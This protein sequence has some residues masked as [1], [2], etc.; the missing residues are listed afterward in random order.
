MTFN[1]IFSHEHTEYVCLQK[2][3][4]NT[5]LF[6]P[7]FV[8]AQVVILDNFM[9]FKV[10]PQI[11]SYSINPRQWYALYLKSLLKIPAYLKCY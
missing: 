11:N 10:K 9:S 2:C 1:I 8:C 6:A 5:T 7:A 4:H 3:P